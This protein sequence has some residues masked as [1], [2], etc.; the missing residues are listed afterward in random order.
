MR[1]LCIR[2]PNPL[3]PL[4]RET[5]V[6]T[7]PLRIRRLAPR[8]DRPV[9]ALLNGRPILRAGWRRRL[10][11]GD[12]LVFAC[13][14]R[15]RGSNPLRLL[16]SLALMAFAPWAAAT[17]LGTTTALV[18][19]TLLGQLTTFGILMAGQALINTV[20][21]APKAPSLPTPSPTY[22]LTAQGNQARIEQ[23]VPVHYGRLLA[24][25]DFAAQ[26]YTEFA[27]GEQYLYQLLCLGA[28][29]YEVEEIRIEDSPITAFEEIE[30]EIIPPGGG[31][32]LFPTSVVTSVEVSGQEL[33]GAV[34]VT[35]LLASGI[36]TVTETGHGRAV[37]QVVR[38]DL[39][40]GGGYLSGV[41]TISAVP[42]ADSW[43]VNALT[44][45]RAC[46]YRI[47]AGAASGTLLWTQSGSRITVTQSAHGRA[48]GA[49]Q[50]VDFAGAQPDGLYLI[51]TVP[52]PDRWTLP[53]PTSG[54]AHG[55]LTATPLGPGLEASWVQG[56]TTVTVTRPGHG[57]SAG[58]SIWLDLSA[59]DGP[60]GWR[61]IATV[62]G[63]DSFTLS[64]GTTGTTGTVRPVLGGATG[65]VASGPDSRATHLGLDLVLPRGLFGL[66]SGGR[67]S[68]KSLRVIVEA[69]RIDAE[70]APLGDWTRIIDKSFTDR[71]A[72]A[73]RR[74]IRHKLTPAGRYAIRAW[75]H[76]AKDGDA[77]VGH[78][79]A[80]F[81]LRAYLRETEDFAGLTLIAMRMRATNNLSLQAS[82]RVGV[83]ATRKLPVWT[84]TGWSAP[85]PTRS[86]A[87]AIADAARNPAYGAK[88]PD[89]RLDLEAL[90]ALDALW[91]AR[92]DR[93][94]ARFDS[95]GSWW[96]S[97]SRIAQA[98]RARVFLQG[99]RLR[100]VRDGAE[101]LP[102]ALFSMRNIVKGS[103]S[104]DYAMPTEATADAIEV[105]YFDSASWSPRRVT[106]RLDGSSAARPA[107]MEAFGITDRAQA[108]REGLYQAA[109][110]RYRRRS[111]K[112][113][114]EMEG[115]I[116]SIGD[117]IAVQHDMPA[118]GAQAEALDWDA[119]ARVLRISEEPLW[120]D[121]PH[122][123]AFRRRNGGVS[124]PWRVLPG[125]AP[126]QLILTETPDMTPDCGGARE[127]THL[128]FGP[129][130]LWAA[131]CKVTAVKPKGLHQ[132]S[133]E[134]VPDDPSVHSAET[135]Q[136]ASPI[137]L[138]SLPRR[139]TRP[140]VTGL[141]AR[142][143]PG[144][145]TRV[146][147]AWRPAPGAD[148]Y[149]VEMAEGDDPA[150]ADVSWTRVTDTSAAQ[151]AVLLLHAARTMI[152][153]RGLGLAAGDW[154]AA[155]LGSLIPAMWNTPATP[156]WTADPNPMWSA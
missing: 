143:I 41:Y 89:S 21:P 137:R 28:G 91:A 15:G 132:V 45:T 126:D 127:R 94:D 115:F 85:Q 84:G 49:A 122:Y 146:L 78:E 43:R 17:L 56:G 37:G 22:S 79:V 52:H 24:Y 39:E 110:N 144:D 136:T 123:V 90:A 151:V 98:G 75:R 155:S 147:L 120:G 154:T 59:G 8:G 68:D 3:D 138:G 32:T 86:I 6:L 100:V 42:S 58:Q 74:S 12:T 71:S 25:P 131:L 57:L 92:G 72:T 47:A 129:G 125:A 88:L 141:I 50:L 29:E 153:V 14:P 97:V 139:V 104:I 83:I 95:A 106:A 142:R 105:S 46:S 9:I 62:P 35:W 101:T 119:G 114:T 66:G 4:H 64:L 44:G 121:G 134:A 2:L 145:N 111:V 1:A 18:G 10:R 107:K 140:R 82:R 51:D 116:P 103:F 81:G 20:L 133:I 7:R 124:G 63:P 80:L 130:M 61:S 67:L 108:L 156:F 102:V 152:R 150:S 5:A 109:A 23:P 65:F 38:L 93:F 96:D 55:T 31:V 148:S 16:A 149:Q 117:L 73:I 13:L 40:G 26:P 70:G 128:A 69:R 11:H 87:W 30:T 118:W 54:F 112:F 53:A 76:D 34:P 60:V 36:I 27:G 113:D 77:G 99:G 48:V 135:G 33:Q 19:T